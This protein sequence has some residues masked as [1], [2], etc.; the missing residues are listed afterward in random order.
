MNRPP[1]PEALVYTIP[2]AADL[3]GI[4]R[5]H[6]Y[7][8]AAQGELPVLR[9]GHRLLVPKA[10]LLDLLAAEKETGAD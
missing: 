10:R 9:L 8:M 1:N 4:S 2:Q 6:A 3:L 7:L 5:N